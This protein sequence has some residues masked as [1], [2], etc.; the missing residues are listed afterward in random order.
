MENSKKPQTPAGPK[1]VSGTIKAIRGNVAYF[2]PDTTGEVMI[3][4]STKLL[5]TAMAGDKVEIK[6]YTKT[7]SGK[8]EGEVVKVTQRAKIFFVGTIDISARGIIVIPDDRRVKVTV[9]IAKD[10]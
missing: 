1:V 7:R 9:R 6:V 3:E 5:N 8:P 2:M 4:I 10:K